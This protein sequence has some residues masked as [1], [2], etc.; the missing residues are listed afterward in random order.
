MLSKDLR[1]VGQSWI[2]KLQRLY[3]RSSLFTQP[4]L[5]KSTQAAIR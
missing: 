2:G 5:I 3:R 4:C 1:R